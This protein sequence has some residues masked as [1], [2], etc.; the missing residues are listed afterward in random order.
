MS[1]ASLWLQ[2]VVI[3]V[4]ALPAAA[5][6]L[7]VA[8]GQSFT[9]PTD[10]GHA[11]FLPQDLTATDNTIDLLVH[12]HGDPATVRN[13]A[14]YAGLNA[15]VLNVNYPGLSSAYSG[16]FR[17]VDLFGN[18]LDG[19]LDT[20]RARPGLPND[21]DFGNVALSS[22]SAGYGAVRE[23]L[24]QPAYVQQIDGVLLA[25][26]L[27]ASFTSS[28]DNTPRD[29]QMVDFRAFASAAAQGNKTM[30][31]THSQVPTF[32]YSN[33][34]ETA[35][36]LMQ[37]VGVTPRAVN[38]TGLGTLDFYR[39]ADAGNFH[40]WGATDSDGDAHLEHLRYV[41]QWLGDLPLDGGAPVEPPEPVTGPVVLAGFETDE[42]P[43]HFDPLFSGSNVGLAAATAERTE[44][45]ARSG[46]AAQRL[47]LTAARGTRGGGWLL[48]HTA[49]GGFPNNNT[50]LPTRGHV[51]L[52]IKT[53]TPG[54]T[55]QLGLDNPDSADL[56]V[57]QA[58]AADGEWHLY[59][60]N[61]EDPDQWQ[62]WAD[63]DGRIEGPT[64][65]LDAVFLRGAG[66]AVVYLDD[67]SYHP[68]GSLLP[69]VIP[70]PGAALPAAAVMLAAKR[71]R[72]ATRTQSTQ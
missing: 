15:A 53:D 38:E 41:G 52:W 10:P 69:R 67:V 44:D 56:A 1:R 71:S 8:T 58:V 28:S 20:L 5:Q 32:T 57:A 43:F 42:T 17:D 40:V 14:A 68:D 55:V 21:L 22:F 72:P 25:D 23:I 61:L 65:T 45:Q 62:P 48:R 54:I 60:W 3:C 59:E 66:D 36:D 30:I 39:R 33:T 7:P 4:L 13:N 27:Y 9:L 37:H 31:V 11:L 16:P 70:E 12:F 50:A 24:K 2:N 34:A 26:S 18:V 63:G 51:G 46:D 47:D 49:A 19:A 6:P 35:D 29:S 64:Y